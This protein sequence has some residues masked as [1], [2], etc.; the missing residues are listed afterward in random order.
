MIETETQSS[1]SLQRMVRPMVACPACEGCGRVTIGDEMWDTLCAVVDDPRQE[2]C[3]VEVASRMKWDGHITAINNR[4]AY[5][6]RLGFL[7]RRKHGRLWMYRNVN[8]PNDPSSAT[9]P[10]RR[11]DCNS[12]A[13]AGFAAA[14]G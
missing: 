2:V 11:H 13:M 6:W 14:H 8:R 12:D 4:L 3:A 7:K 9:R 1:R 10:A 5:L